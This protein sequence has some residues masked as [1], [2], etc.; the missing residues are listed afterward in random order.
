MDNHINNTS[1][2]QLANFRWD[3]YGISHLVSL[4]KKLQGTNH[5]VSRLYLDP[6]LRIVM[7]IFII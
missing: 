5:R 6:E 7:Y 3:L 4:S 1:V 2:M